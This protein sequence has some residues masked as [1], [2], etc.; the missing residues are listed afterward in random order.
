MRIKAIIKTHMSNPKILILL[1]GVLIH[2][3]TGFL[4]VLC[5]GSDGQTMVELTAQAHCECPEDLAIEEANADSSIFS[6]KQGHCTDSLYTLNV[7]FT[8]QEKAKQFTIQVVAATLSTKSEATDVSPVPDF[9]SHTQPVSSF[10]T[11][12]RTIILLA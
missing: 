7:I 12:L 11:P 9:S 4:T 8:L 6:D 10:H 3:T 2:S 5:H 1:L